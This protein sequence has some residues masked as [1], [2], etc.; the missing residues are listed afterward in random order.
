MTKFDDAWPDGPFGRTDY[1]I[2]ARNTFRKDIAYFL[3]KGMTLAEITAEF[4]KA[5]EDYQS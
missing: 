1:P 5:S 3:S 4:T 2:V